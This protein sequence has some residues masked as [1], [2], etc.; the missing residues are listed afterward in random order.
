[1]VC[2]AFC[3]SRPGAFHLNGVDALWYVCEL[4]SF[5]GNLDVH[6]LTFIYEGAGASCAVYYAK[7]ILCNAK[8]DWAMFV[9]AGVGVAAGPLFPLPMV[10]NHGFPPQVS[11]MFLWRRPVVC[12]VC[13]DQGFP[14]KVSGSCF[15]GV[16][17]TMLYCT[18]VYYIIVACLCFK[19]WPS[20]RPHGPSERIGTSAHASNAQVLFDGRRQRFLGITFLV[21]HT[22]VDYLY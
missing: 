2:G 15:Q 17:Y 5:S 14:P 3:L 10:A 18:V 13:L 11:I 6:T 9:A 1:M 12:F 20:T 4:F 22:L 16:L 19:L 7:T 8:L 21:H